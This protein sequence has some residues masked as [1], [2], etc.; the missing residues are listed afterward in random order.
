MENFKIRINTEAQYI[1]EVNDKGDTIS[2]D[3]EDIDFIFRHERAYK[4]VN[5]AVSNLQAELLL[6]GKKQDKTDKGELMSR[7]TKARVLA[8]KKAFADMR[9]AYDEFLGE[10]AC[11]MI[12]GQKNTLRMFRDLEE[13]LQPVYDKMKEN[14]KSIPEIISNK[15]GDDTES[16]EVL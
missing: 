11:D 5:E 16:G 6:I 3:P 10:G 4:A 14:L 12:F 7:N 13:A 1:V 15:Y 9:K 8:Y 2:F